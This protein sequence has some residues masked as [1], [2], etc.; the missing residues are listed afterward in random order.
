M[1]IIPKTE[2]NS[3][4]NNDGNT[5][6]VTKKAVKAAMYAP[7]IFAICSRKYFLRNSFKSRIA[8][9]SFMALSKPIVPKTRST[10]PI[11]SP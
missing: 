11:V 1:K 3:Q 4:L 5:L 9:K 7:E 8:L 2:G 6:F 10:Q